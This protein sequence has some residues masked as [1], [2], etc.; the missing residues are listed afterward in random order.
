MLLWN[1][2]RVSVGCAETETAPHPLRVV[3]RREAAMP[4]YLGILILILLFLPGV[5]L[6]ALGVMGL[7]RSVDT[8]RKVLSVIALLVGAA[9]TVVLVVALVADMP[10]WNWLLG[11]AAGG[12]WLAAFAFWVMVLA[13]CLLNEKGEGNE[14]IVWTIVIIFTLIVGAALYYFLRRPRRVAEVGR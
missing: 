2:S 1:A 7:R 14:R 5:V 11:I 9:L 3:E 6:L 10:P 4:G 13:D 12:L 8:M